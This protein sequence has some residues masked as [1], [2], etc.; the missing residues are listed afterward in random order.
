MSEED[1]DDDMEESLKLTFKTSITEEDKTALFEGEEISEEYKEKTITIF[2]ASVSSKVKELA[3]Q[4]QEHYKLVAEKK[5][6]KLETSLQNQV[7]E[8][9]D[10]VVTEWVSENEIAIENGLKNDMNEE[11]LDGLKGL[12]QEHYIEVPE[13]RYDILEGLA[14]KVETL[15]EELDKQLASNA[16][17]MAE[18]KVQSKDKII[19]T[20]S[21]GLS[22]NQADKFAALVEHVSSDDLNEFETKALSLK[23]SYFK[24]AD[25]AKENSNAITESDHSTSNVINSSEWDKMIARASGHK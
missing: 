8:Y 23:E 4:A 16:S 2:E 9:L 20:L 11:F 15:E 5:V 24:A 7:N 1:E 6:A 12:F 18:N 22:D 13:Q 17:L 25:P 21:E 10:Y 19:A 14:D 3:E